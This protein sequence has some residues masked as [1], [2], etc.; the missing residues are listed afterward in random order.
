MKEF[1]G[2]VT[3]NIDHIVA[4]L[5]FF[6]PELVLTVGFVLSIIVALFVDRIWKHASFVTF[7]VTA[8]IAFWTV[9]QQHGVESSGFFGMIRIDGF[10]VYARLIILSGVLVSGVML[11]QYFRDSQFVRKPGD[12][13][14]VLIA[15]TLGLHLLTITTH[16]LVAFIAIEMVSIGSYI[17]V[18]YFSENKK[19]S[20]AAMKYVLFG[21][22]CA[23]FM[24]YGLSL[25]YGFTGD[26]DFV[27]VAHMKGLIASPMVLSTVALLFVFVGIGFKLGFVPFHLWT[28]DVY[29]G[30]PTPVT[31]FL[32]TVPKVGAVVLF[33]RI[34]KAWTAN[35]FYFG[36]V[37]MYFLFF[38]AV[39]TMLAGNLIALRQQN[40]KRLMAYSSIGH[41]GFMLMA[42]LCYLHGEQEIFLFY[43]A[44]Y[45][46]MNLSAFGFIYVLEQ[47]VQSAYLQDY[48]GLGKKWPLLFG[49]F[50]FVGIS[51]VGLP[52]TAGFIGKLTVLT[53]VFDLYQTMNER[54]YLILLIVGVAT[55]VI[56]LFFYLKVPLYAFLREEE[57]GGQVLGSYNRSVTY[58]IAVVLSLGILLVGLF[59]QV[60]FSLF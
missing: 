21:A 50:T 32:S 36:E 52:P 10:G 39:V 4:S 57:R 6:R 9:L 26:L 34:V 25:L 60:L 37:V 11:W 30:A 46:I 17:L 16:W 49:C 20:E 38:V 51:L 35:P 3:E 18:G 42:M 41:T 43:V 5:G 45:V 48:T 12:L 13:F 22:V 44:V 23:A 14:T 40:A 55:S 24:L 33:C 58:F 59:P 56:S 1:A 7:I 19:Q 2:H 28:P 29:E 47:R 31:A 53:S 15:T 27:S 8:F 54:L